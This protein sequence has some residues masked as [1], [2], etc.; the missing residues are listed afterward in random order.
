MNMIVGK[1]QI[2]LASLVAALGV[3]VYL[4]YQFAGEDLELVTANTTQQTAVEGA[5]EETQE[6]EH[7]GDAQFVDSKQVARNAQEDGEYFSQARLTRQKTRDQAQEALQVMLT[8]TALT[9]E[10]KDELTAQAGGMVQAIETEGR[11]EN[12]I[13]AKG[14]D[15]CMVYC[16]SEKVDVI[17]K[18]PELQEGQVVQIR[19]IILGETKVPVENIS[20]VSVK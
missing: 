20:I 13:K 7:Y 6:Q 3:A 15:E 5:L 9:Q 17:V 14:F 16:S 19:D 12:R 2:V 11:I 18:A 10:Q 8:D 4:N 1:K